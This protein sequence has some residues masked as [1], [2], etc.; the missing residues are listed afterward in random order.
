MN[1]K[2]AI[3]GSGILTYILKVRQTSNSFFIKKS[4]TIK[5]KNF[6]E[7][8]TIGGNSNIWGGYIN[9]ERHQK[10]LK[11]TKYKNFINKKFFKIKEIFSGLKQFKNTNCIVDEKINF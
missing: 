7:F 4:L 3:L 1:F 11:N 6:Y 9:Y 10:F 2:E 8:D 5:S